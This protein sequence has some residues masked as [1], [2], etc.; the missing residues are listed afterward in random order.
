MPGPE[1]IKYEKD[2]RDGAI[3][4]AIA[5]KGV[6]CCSQEFKMTAKKNKCRDVPTHDKHSYSNTD[7]SETEYCH[8]SQV[9]GRKKKRIGAI[10]FHE[11]SVDRSE[12]YKPEYE[13]NLVP[14]E[15]QEQ[16]LNWQ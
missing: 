7:K 4:N 3:I 13:Q 11:S 6:C 12:K 16:Q 10:I 1:K 5:K 8:I 14:P 2:Q 15:M 9:L